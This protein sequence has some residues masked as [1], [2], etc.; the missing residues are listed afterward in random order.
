M[1][2]IFGLLF[3]TLLLFLS[4]T[5]AFASMISDAAGYDVATHDNATWQRLG[6]SSTLDDG[7]FWSND[8]GSTW[9][10]EEVF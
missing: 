4:Q 7:V 6:A 8:G 3:V 1:K 5:T 10:H 9:G 2:K